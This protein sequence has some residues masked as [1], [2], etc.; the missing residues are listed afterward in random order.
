[1][2]NALKFVAAMVKNSVSFERFLPARKNSTLFSLALFLTIT[3]M[4][5]VK[6]RYARTMKI[7]LSM[8]FSPI[9]KAIQPIK[10]LDGFHLA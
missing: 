8:A 4:T 10:G 3:P 2:V 1:M 6:S 7:L 5:R 9:K